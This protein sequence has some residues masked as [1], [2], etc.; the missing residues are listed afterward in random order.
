MLSKYLK[1]GYLITICTILP[2]YMAHGYHELGESKAIVY[3]TM[4]LIF[5][6]LFLLAQNRNFFRSG[7]L[8]PFLSYALLTFLFSNVISF[9]YSVEKKVSFL[10]L[11]GWRN[12]LLTTLLCLF[13][14][15][16]F[17]E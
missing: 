10:G 7:K 6:L 8:S 1:Y 14:F 2:L 13:F 5:A 15:Y 16:V 9:V 11:S 3:I 12:G 4:S 17:Y